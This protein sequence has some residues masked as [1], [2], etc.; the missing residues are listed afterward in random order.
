MCHCCNMLFISAT[1]IGDINGSPSFFY[2]IRGYYLHLL[3]DLALMVMGLDDK[4]CTICVSEQ[5]PYLC[6][7]Y[8]VFVLPVQYLMEN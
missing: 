5:L 2:S 4:R 7:L 6:F 1:V 8:F 3:F